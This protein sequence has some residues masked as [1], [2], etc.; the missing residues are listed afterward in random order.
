[1]GNRIRDGHPR[2]VGQLDTQ[3]KILTTPTRLT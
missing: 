1:M 3:L 2:I